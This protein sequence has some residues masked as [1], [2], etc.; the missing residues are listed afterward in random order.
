MNVNGYDVS[1]GQQQACLQA[2]TGIFK[3]EDVR[4]AAIQSGVPELWQAVSSARVEDLPGLVANRI[5]NRELRA[6]RIAEEGAP[7]LYRRLD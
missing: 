7:N 5:I 1:H 2:M 3:T 4:G 6:E